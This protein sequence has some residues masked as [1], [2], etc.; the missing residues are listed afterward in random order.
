MDK[1]VFN[2]FQSDNKLF[3]EIPP[4]KLVALGHKVVS[5]RAHQEKSELTNQINR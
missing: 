4:F 3:Q 2:S 1:G 5:S